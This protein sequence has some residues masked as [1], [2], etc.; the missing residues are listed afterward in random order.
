MGLKDGRRAKEGFMN[1][2]F[3]GAIMVIL[4]AFLVL[5]EEASE[6]KYR[7]HELERMLQFDYTVE[8]YYLL[9]SSDTLSLE[10]DIGYG[11][12]DEFI[13][14]DAFD[15][16]Q[17]IEIRHMDDHIKITGHF[18]GRARGNYEIRK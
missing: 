16:N 5:T 9:L 10:K 1:I 18:F 3:A 11:S 8:A 17:Y 15:E 12:L 14:T 2:F 6:M 7:R 4:S 13:L